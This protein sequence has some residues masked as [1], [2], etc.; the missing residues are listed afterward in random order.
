MA[1]ERERPESKTGVSFVEVTPELSEAQILA[2]LAELWGYDSEMENGRDVVIRL[3]AAVE[4]A[5][6]ASASSPRTPQQP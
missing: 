4:A 2:G 1:P 6:R 5:R 3:V